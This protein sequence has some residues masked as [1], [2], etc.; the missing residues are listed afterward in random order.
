M[1]RLHNGQLSQA[2]PDIQNHL[3]LSFAAKDR[4]WM[5]EW[6]L[7]RHGFPRDTWG[8]SQITMFIAKLSD[9]T[10]TRQTPNH[11][12]SPQSIHKPRV[13]SFNIFLWQKLDGLTIACTQN[14]FISEKNF[15]SKTP[16]SVPAQCG[17][18]SWVHLPEILKEARTTPSKVNSKRHAMSRS[19]DKGGRPRPT[20]SGMNDDRTTVGHRGV[21]GDLRQGRFTWH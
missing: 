20:A 13:A 9:V 15:I 1:K 19:V 11:Q 16:P 4:I 18:T 10:L 6:G 12:L 3:K 5:N 2:L 8:A 14:I 17:T 21:D 7:L